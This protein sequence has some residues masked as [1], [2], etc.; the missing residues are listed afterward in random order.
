MQ[1][2][3]KAC[4]IPKWLFIL[5]LVVLVLR[6]P[7][8]F[9]PYSYGDEMIYLTLGEGVRQGVPLYSGIH[10]NKPPL[11]YLVAAVAGSLFWFKAIL[12]IWHL[13]TVFLFWKLTK[14]LF[15]HKQKA[16]SNQ[17]SDKTKLHF[18]A[19]VI[20]AFLT[21]IPLLEGNIANA[22]LFMLG[23]TILAFI[24]LLKYKLTPKNLFL[25]GVLFSISTLFKVPAAFDIP[26]IVFLWFITNK[27]NKKNIKQIITATFYLSLGFLFP[28]IIT[29]I[30]FTLKGAFSQYLVAAFLQ[31][32]GYLSS[33]R[34]GD[35]Q[36]PFIIKNF[37]LL[38]RASI[39]LLSLIVLFWKRKKLSKQFIF[40]T[41]WLLLSLFAVT[42][43]ERPYPHY[44][45]Q[46]V[47]AISILL[48]ILFTQK[49]LEQSYT[50]L[51]LTIAFLVPVYFNFWYYPIASYYLRFIKFSFQ[52]IPKNEYL[53]SFGG[54]V[55]RNYN[56]SE[57]IVSSTLKEDKIFVWGNSS[58]IYALSKRLPPIKF[59]ADY[60]I[61][62]FS[63]QGEVLQALNA[64][65][66]KII[67][68]LPDSDPFH[69]LN[70]FL[71]RNYIQLETIDNAQIW[72][73]IGSNARGL[74]AP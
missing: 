49:T 69:K 29:F 22:E 47:P 14:T 12:A 66:P 35:V 70:L 15:P 41:I 39:V 65:P 1:K 34:P 19:T 11:L 44:L 17:R 5:L 7:S 45:I 30:W 64:S 20:F 56:I 37:P 28:I 53:K 18:I 62:D 61:K 27:L 73:L 8:F 21:T 43:S 71:S 23:P 10:D 50:I 55:V 52:Q 6:I 48:A 46:S 36:E 74:I 63:S 3:L 60:H 13:F 4:H 31:N 38:F 32:V 67:V 58:A 72:K 9:E 25:S 68:V 57:F 42:L 40:L 24:I 2:I 59:V 33:W 16:F 54:D 51:P 26:T